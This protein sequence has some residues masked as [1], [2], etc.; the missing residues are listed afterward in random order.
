MRPFLHRLRGVRITGKVFIGDDVYIENEYNENVEMHDGAQIS[1]RTTII[2][3][4][5]GN[6]KIVIGKNVCIG[7]CCSIA[8]SPDKTTTIGEAA[9]IGM[10][11]SVISSIPPYTLAYGSPA[12]PQ[13]K[14]QIPMTL[15]TRYSQWRQGIMP[16]K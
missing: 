4:F 10:H 1:L 14:T 9:V 15:S 13:Y 8:A 3:H 2:A 5:R 16:I 12:K 11:S 6:G 7:M